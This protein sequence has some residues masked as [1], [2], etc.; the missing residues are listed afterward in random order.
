[1]AE[2]TCHSAECSCITQP[3]GGFTTP[4]ACCTASYH[5]ISAAQQFASANVDTT[6]GGRFQ[7]WTDQFTASPLQSIAL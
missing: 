1:R 5:A 2:S 4:R 7:R 3:G 6:F